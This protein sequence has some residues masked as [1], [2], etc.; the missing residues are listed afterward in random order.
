MRNGWFLPLY[1]L[2]SFVHFKQAIKLLEAK[3]KLCK[4]ATTSI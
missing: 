3:K 4:I 1:D 2:I